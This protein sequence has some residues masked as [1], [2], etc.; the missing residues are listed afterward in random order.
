MPLQP[1]ADADAVAN[2]DFN[3]T[4]AAAAA[5]ET[6]RCAVVAEKRKGGDVECCVCH[7]DLG[8]RSK[9][10]FIRGSFFSPFARR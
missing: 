6:V 8:M 7:G 5:A 4:A 9:K 3:A 10:R 2:A 1:D